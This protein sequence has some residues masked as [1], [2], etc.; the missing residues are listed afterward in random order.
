VTLLTL[1]PGV[2]G[3]VS[4]GGGGGND[5]SI[6]PSFPNPPKPPDRGLVGARYLE[7][8]R[9]G[10]V[11]GEIPRDLDASQ[12]E[13]PIHNGNRSIPVYMIPDDGEY[14]FRLKLFTPRRNADVPVQIANPGQWQKERPQEAVSD[15]EASQ[16][17]G[18][19][20]FRDCVRSSSWKTADD[21]RR[22]SRDKP[23]HIQVRIPPTKGFERV[24]V[25]I[26]KPAA[27]LG[28][29]SR[30]TRPMRWSPIIPTDIT[31]YVDYFGLE[32][33][34]RHAPR[35]APG[36][37]GLRVRTNP[38]RTSRAKCWGGS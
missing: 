34:A 20:Q 10:S 15:A 37:A 1:S 35:F 36:A 32:G 22:V 13:T 8:R 29:A 23:D 16:L 4:G 17:S 3:T 33:A 27:G 14:N 26:V 2:D 11:R 28:A 31:L 18:I 25:A 21:S 30:R 38:G 5:R 12:Y 6:G 19:W 7:T 9:P 24:G